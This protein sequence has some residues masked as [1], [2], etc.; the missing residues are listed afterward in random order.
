MFVE[1]GYYWPDGC[2]S[3]TA[4]Y[5]KHMGDAEAAIRL[6]PKPRKV[7]VQ[8]GG[9]VGLWPLYLAKRFKTVVTFEPE[10]Q[11]FECLVKNTRAAGHV[12]MHHAMLGERSGNGTIRASGKNPGGHRAFYDGSGETKVVAIDDLGLEGVGLICLDVEGCELPA[13]KG[14]WRTISRCRPVIMFEQRGHGER[15]GYT[16]TDLDAWLMRAGYRFV[17]KVSRD[18]IW[19]HG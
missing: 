1:S 16:D 18:R 17:K 13:L 9:F 7:A 5:L 15:L 11:N 14:A 10:P 3:K 6:V 4:R 19:A 8:A 2:A 12:V